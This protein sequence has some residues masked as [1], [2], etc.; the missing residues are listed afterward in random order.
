MRVTPDLDQSD[1]ELYS[2]LA[3]LMPLHY[4]YERRNLGLPD[5]HFLG[6][7]EV[8][9]PYRSLLVHSSDMTPTLAAFH[10]SSL[11]LKVHEHESSE[12][13]EMRLVTL[14][15]QLSN[16]PVEFGA[17]AIQLENFPAGMAHEV[18]DRQK[19]LGGL[20]AEFHVSHHGAPVAYFSVPADELIASALNQK[21]GDILY[22]RCNQLHDDAGIVF[23]DIVEILPRVLESENTE[24]D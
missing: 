2:A 9:E 12:N 5:F 10:G 21:V 3:W 13:F 4:F 23:A 11:S 19:P 24:Q 15:S 7:S 22:G 8:P 14:H 20:L 6:G 16:Q 17:I 18:T 1:A